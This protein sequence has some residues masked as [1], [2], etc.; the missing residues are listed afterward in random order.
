MPPTK[1]ETCCSLRECFVV[2]IVH[3]VRE[4]TFDEVCDSMHSFENQQIK[5][6]F[7]PFCGKPIDQSQPMRD[8]HG[9]PA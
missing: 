7:C 3:M 9:N 5:I 8:A 1:S 4:P 2:G 6:R